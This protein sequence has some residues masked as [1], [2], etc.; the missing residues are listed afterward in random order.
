[1]TVIRP[2]SFNQNKKIKKKKKKSANSFSFKAGLGVETNF[3][4]DR[5]FLLKGNKPVFSKPEARRP[6]SID[7]SHAILKSLAK[8]N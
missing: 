8:L 6:G 1:M 2:P 5:T 4:G 7:V 3:R